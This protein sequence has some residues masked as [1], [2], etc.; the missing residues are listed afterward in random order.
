LSDHWTTEEIYLRDLATGT[1]ERVMNG[2]S[3]TFEAKKGDSGSRF[4]LSSSGDGIPGNDESAKITVNATGDGKI[5]I[6][7]NGSRDCTAF[8]SDTGGKHL[9][10][11]EVRAGKEQVVENITRGIYIVRLQNAVVNDVRRVV[12]E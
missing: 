10:Q 11:L 5:V 4:R 7:N 9:Q 1:K 8:V 3:Y 12:V 2:G 6:S